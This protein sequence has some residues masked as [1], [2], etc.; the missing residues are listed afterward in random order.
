MTAALA[1]LLF[2]LGLG[3]GGMTDP[4]NIH[5]F[6]DIAG[7]WNPSLLWVMGGA[8]AVYAPARRVIR[9]RMTKPLLTPGFSVERIGRPDLPLVVGTGLFGIGWG[10][11][12]YCPGPA[13]VSLSS[14]FLPPVLFV[15][16]MGVGMMLHRPFRNG[17][18]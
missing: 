3:L 17:A 1:G 10:L 5:G 15:L 18:E 16:S 8:L 2:A 12:G 6:L 11:S 13:L 4:E 14:G 9:S 7:A